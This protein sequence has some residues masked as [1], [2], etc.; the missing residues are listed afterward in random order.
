MLLCATC[1]LFTEHHKNHITKRISCSVCAT[2][3]ALHGTE[4]AR[5]AWVTVDAS[6]A[7]L[8]GL[9]HTL[10][11]YA[12]LI[13]LCHMPVSHLPSCTLPGV[14]GLLQVQEALDAAAQD[15]AELVWE[16]WDV[17]DREFLDARGTGFDREAWA[18]K[19][20]AALASKR[21]TPILPHPNLTQSNMIQHSFF[22]SCRWSIWF[23]PVKTS[24]LNEFSSSSK[25]PGWEL[26]VQASEGRISVHDAALV[27]RSRFRLTG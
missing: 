8:T 4:L 6:H 2:G 11:S 14:S 9:C 19:R 5:E 25:L 3:V 7:Y 18:A 27:S 13:C 15:G 1:K 17:V 16:V 23:C 12:Y 20:D 10:M 21:N 26:E 22:L 24:K